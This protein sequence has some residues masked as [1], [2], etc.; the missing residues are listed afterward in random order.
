MDNPWYFN[1]KATIFHGITNVDRHNPLLLD[2]WREACRHIEIVESLDRIVTL[3]ARDLPATQILI[4][5]LSIERLAFETVASASS[6]A[7]RPAAVESHSPVPQ[8]NLEGLL[9]WIQQ[10]DATKDSAQTLRLRLPG[11]LPGRMTGELLV[12]PMASEHGHRGAVIAVADPTRPFQAEHLWLFRELLEP[13][14]VA[15][16]NDRR[17]RELVVLRERAEAENRALMAKLGR[18]EGAD[19]VVGEESGLRPV[20]ERVQ[21]V[22]KSD[23][24]VL[25]LGETGSGKE[26]IARA[27]H[28][29]S[30]RENGPF[31][32][33]NCGAIP[34][35]LIDSELFGHEKGS[36]TGAEGRRK[37]WFERADGG[38]LFLDECGELPPA[39]QVRLLRVLQDSSFERVGGEQSL[40]VDVRVIAATHRDLKA[41]VAEQTFR[42]DLWYRLAVFPIHL[43]P[44]RERLAD[45]PAMARHFALRAAHKLGLRPCMPTEDQLTLLIHYPWPGNVRELASVMDRAAIL[46]AGETLDVAAALGTSPTKPPTTD[47]PTRPEPRRAETI[48]TRFPSLD[49][50]AAAHIESALVYTK[51]RIEGPHGAAR[52]LGINP[53]TLRS[54]MRKLD[55]DWQ[56]FRLQENAESGRDI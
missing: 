30:R 18:S 5:E 28:R 6:N 10:G 37:G 51:G 56:K 39:V 41:M 43:P 26:V 4:R 9:E 3:I 44:L 7:T 52:L 13:F 11:L 21:R 23:V 49:E 1:H 16:E 12:G 38:T 8:Q 53:H 15:L 55:I 31:V 42:E 14:T 46:G 36:F 40:H 17:L 22:A 54:R 2:V 33:V 48:V 29:Q 24:P 25:I 32:R 19:Q 45:I 35:E 47:A 34:P 20:M 27:I 50:A